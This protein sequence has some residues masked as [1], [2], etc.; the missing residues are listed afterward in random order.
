MTH[1]SS[2]QALQPYLVFM[3]AALSALTPLA[4]DIYLAAIPTIAD[5][6]QVPFHDVE[7]SISLYMISF[8]VGQLL[9]GPFSDYIGR[10]A[11]VRIGLGIFVIASTL[12]LAVPTLEMLWLSRV[13]QAFGGGIGERQCG[14]DHSR[15]Q[16][17]Q[18]RR[19]Q[20]GTGRSGDDVR[21]ADCTV[22]G[23]DHS[24]TGELAG[25]FWLPAVVFGCFAGAVSSPSAGDKTDAGQ[26]ESVSALRGG[27]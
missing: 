5:Q 25:D 26:W 24:E 23:N 16:P 15:R 4:I 18:G 22:T 7:I 8:S 13:L 21:A 11:S 6:L 3:L 1:S 12:T 9:G 17:W 2:T 10:R 27:A 20:S 14:R 19:C